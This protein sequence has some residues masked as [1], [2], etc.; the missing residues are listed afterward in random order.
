[1]KIR[2]ILAA[3]ACLVA[4]FACSKVNPDEDVTSVSG[5][6]AGE[7]NH[8]L[9]TV[10]YDTEF[11][12]VWTATVANIDWPVKGASAS[13]QKLA[14]RTLMEEVKSAGCNVVVLQ[15]V[16]NADAIYPSKLLPW[17]VLLTGTQGKDPG[18]DPLAYAVETAHSLGLELHAWF[19]P[20]RIGATSAVRVSDHPMFQH[21][22]WWKEMDGAYYWNPGLPEVRAFL[23]AIMEEVVTNYDV[24]GTHI[25]DYFYRAGVKGKGYTN[26]DDSAQYNL[27]NGGKSLDDWRTWNIDE[28]VKGYLEVTHA[29]KG[30]AVFGV[31]PAG[32]LALTQSYC[33]DPVHWVAQGS[34]DYLTPQIYWSSQRGGDFADFDDVVLPSWVAMHGNVPLM[35]GLASYKYSQAGFEDVSE[36]LYEVKTS[37]NAGCVGN[38]WYNTT[39]VRRA[40]V[41]SYLAGTVYPKQALTPVLSRSPKQLTPPVPS[42]SGTLI[43]WGET[44][45]ADDYV[46]LRLTRATGTSSVWNAAV[47]SSGKTRSFTG[48]KGGYYIVLSRS[49]AARST[50]SKVLYLE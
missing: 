4:V 46:V 48:T 30:S 22:D 45:G 37:R 32:R 15:V 34:L 2:A 39:S 35:P 19:N 38:F 11:R 26:W 17:S 7:F 25:D 5:N 33:A 43:T 12:A 10:R 14:L 36:Y 13:A 16:S 42:S 40:E 27:Y 6:C 41:H 49:G 3:A 1:M 29:S 18:Y 50:Y 31:S 47:V 20:L 8:D 23:R 44:A 21:K 9:H 28:M 24:D